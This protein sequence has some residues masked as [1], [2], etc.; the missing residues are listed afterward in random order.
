MAGDARHRMVAR[1]DSTQGACDEARMGPR[2]PRARRHPR[3]RPA[4]RVRRAQERQSKALA[5]ELSEDRSEHHAGLPRPRD[6]AHP[7]SRGRGSPEAPAAAA[8]LAIEP[9]R[10]RPK[11]RLP[12]QQPPALGREKAPPAPGTLTAT[13]LKV[14]PML[15]A[16][17]LLAVPAPNGKPRVKLRLRLPERPMTADIAAKS[18]PKAQTAHC[19]SVV[20]MP[21]VK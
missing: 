12:P 5:G 15:N 16:A 6:A 2:T 3:P 13:R 1:L 21:H 18:L 8:T 14:S 4:G 20:F 17:E 7:P 19:C 11:V 9:T 10:C